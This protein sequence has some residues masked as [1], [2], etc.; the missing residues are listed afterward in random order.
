MR[1]VYPCALFLCFA[2]EEKSGF[3]LNQSGSFLQQC[4]AAEGKWIELFAL[5]WG[6]FFP[7]LLIPRG[8]PVV[9][10]LFIIDE[11]VHRQC[12]GRRVC[13]LNLNH[14]EDPSPSS[15]HLFLMFR[16][17]K[18]PVEILGI[19]L[20]RLPTAHRKKKPQTV[21]CGL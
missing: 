14:R 3:L 18:C 19:F 9:L 4:H 5:R 11:N 6:V 2:L 15:F 17:G 13:L 8:Q 20:A 21:H 12:L 7:L 16:A 1:P 10:L